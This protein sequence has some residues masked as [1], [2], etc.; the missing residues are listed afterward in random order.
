VGKPI[1]KLDVTTTIETTTKVTINGEQL[2]ELL[3]ANGFVPPSDHIMD[4]S[5][6][7]NVPDQMGH[8]T[9]D[10]LRIDDDTPIRILWR[11]QRKEY[12]GPG[13]HG[14]MDKLRDRACKRCGEATDSEGKC[15]DKH[16]VAWAG[17]LK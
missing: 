10:G 17:P 6:H 8:C 9:G 11:T 13:P 7:V 3:I 4:Y 16:C 2:I 1:V 14:P 5:V 12:E 15:P